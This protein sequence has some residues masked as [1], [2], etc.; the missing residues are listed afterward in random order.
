MKYITQY[1]LFESRSNFPLSDE[2]SK[3]K[4]DILDIFM[5]IKDKY[6]IECQPLN[7]DIYVGPIVYWIEFKKNTII[8]LIDHDMKI[9]KS[10][11][12]IDTLN[13]LSLDLEDFVKRLQKMGL[14]VNYNLERNFG[15]AG[16]TWA[17]LK[18]KDI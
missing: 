8:F 15:D 4:D 5:D 17:E 18:I 10:Q 11:K 3:L 2:Q 13:D 7:S 12:G 16:K 14:K 6:D 9:R 1:K